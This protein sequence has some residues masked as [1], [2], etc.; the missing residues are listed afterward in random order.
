[1][2]KNSKTQL[3]DSDDT[4]TLITQNVTR[5]R[6][7]NNMKRKNT[8]LQ[9]GTGRKRQRPTKSIDISLILANIEDMNTAS[10]IELQYALTTMNNKNG[11]SPSLILLTETWECKL[12]R[13]EPQL[14]G[15]RYIGKPI[16]RL[17]QATRAHGGTGV[18]V[19]TTIANQC[20]VINPTKSNQNILWIQMID[21]NNTTYVA[22]VYSRPGQPKEHQEIMKTL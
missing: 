19:K 17:P 15:Y 10:L 16:D 6:R 7:C 5:T 9:Y 2:L 3:P 12:S 11:F 1:M 14:K 8:Q 21:E 22:V 18:W 20:S 13:T 4:S